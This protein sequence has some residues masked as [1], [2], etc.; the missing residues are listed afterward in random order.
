MTLKYK[1]ALME[2]MLLVVSILT[3]FNLFFTKKKKLWNPWVNS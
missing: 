3:F 1:V 2:W